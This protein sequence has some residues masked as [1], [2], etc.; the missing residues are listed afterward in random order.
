LFV[1][2]AVRIF[3]GAAITPLSSPLPFYAYPVLV[4]TMGG[5]I[6]TLILKAGDTTAPDEGS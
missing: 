4:T 2:T 5:W 1:I 3:G 6:W